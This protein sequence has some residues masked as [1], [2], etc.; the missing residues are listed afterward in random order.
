MA[1]KNTN[2]PLVS[3]ITPAYN[4]GDYINEAIGSVLFQTYPNWELIVVDD[5]S[6]DDTAEIVKNYSARDSRIKYHY[7]ENQR[8][9]SARN[10]GIKLAQGKYVVFLDADN[11]FLPNKI[12]DQVQFMEVNPKCGLAYSKILHFYNEEPGVFY[13]NKNEVPFRG[14]DFFRET[15][16]RNF[17]N[18]LSVIVRKEVFD[19]FGAFQQ[20]WE[21]CDE[22]YVWVNL[23]Y[24][25]VRFCY[26]D[27]IVGHL[28]LHKSSDS[29]NRFYVY[30]ASKKFLDLLDLVESWLTNE[31][32]QKYELDIKL[33]RK[34]WRK[35][36]F[37]G[38]LIKSPFFSWIL[39]PLF[40]TRR[41]RNFYPYRKR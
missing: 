7:Q 33:L 5:G 10:A 16:H 4:A 40:R 9:A 20:G 14:D 22:Q 36:M 3:I 18:V 1:D 26:L 41:D 29:A 19:K 30:V 21:A 15:L 25:K 17:I 2:L 11:L 37:I 35:K 8:M 13:K 38:R 27:K 39:L 6:T 32:R 24:H 34:S 31:E 12:K 28:R 23:S